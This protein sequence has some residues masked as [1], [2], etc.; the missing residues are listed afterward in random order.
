M[1]LYELASISS[2]FLSG[3]SLNFWEQWIYD[4]IQIKPMPTI[5]EDDDV[6]IKVE[7]PED[8]DQS[9]KRQRHL[10]CSGTS[11]FRGLVVK[12]FSKLLGFNRIYRMKL[13]HVR[14]L[15]F[16]PL[17]CEVTKNKDVKELQ[18]LEK[19][20]F[21]AIKKGHVEYITHL[22][23]A[24]YK[25]HD[26]TN[27]KGRNIFQF[28]AECRQHKIFSLLYGLGDQRNWE[29]F[30]SG[31]DKSGNNM[32]HVVGT[33]SSA[34]QINRIQGPA[35][36]MQRELQWFK[37]VE[38]LARPVDHEVI[39]KTDEMT[40]RELFTKGHKDLVKEG[41]KAMK[42]TATSCTVVGALIVTIMFAAAST[43]P[44][45][46][47]QDTALSIML[48]GKS[49]IAILLTLLTSVPVASFIWTQFSLLFE[50][51]I[52]TYGAGVFDRKIKN[53]PRQDAKYSASC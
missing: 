45:G 31:K 36:Q 52:S 18:G 53:W 3:S 6:R 23:R 8:G 2:A 51:V 33:I 7:I 32:L 4:G 17:M 39:N 50:L 13:A 12:T 1:P 14:I 37:E 35:L 47:K 19:A 46:N 24:N 11:L 48:Q 34:A 5:K 16:L 43:V 42:D 15:E 27:E 29:P 44:G 20:M 26:I 38:R 25:L 41:E 28:A 21:L 22:C 9:N 30:V 10:I 49:S 40:P